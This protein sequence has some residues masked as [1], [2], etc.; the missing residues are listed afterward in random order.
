[1]TCVRTEKGIETET[2]FLAIASGKEGEHVKSLKKLHN[3]IQKDLVK[4]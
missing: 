4:L 3:S 2:P 1:M